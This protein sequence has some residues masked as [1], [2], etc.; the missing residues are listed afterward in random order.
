MSQVRNGRPPWRVLSIALAAFV[1]LGLIDGALGV[2]WPSMR[3]FF[4][5]GVAEL[6]LLLT[7]GSLGYMIAS[8][9]YGRLHERWGTG[10]LLGTGCTLLFLGA[11][12]YALSPLW[13]LVALSAWLLGLGGGL[14]DTG[15]NAHAALA[16]DVGSV[17]LLH[18]GY[19]VGA[20]MGP[21]V[22]TASLV[23]SS[24]WRWG[25][26]AIA[27]CQ[28][29]TTLAVWSQRSRWAAPDHSGHD[30]GSSPI[31][32]RASFLLAV[33]MFFLYTGMEVG[34]G[35][36]AFTLLAEGRG[37]STAAAGTW[38]A[39]YWGG[40]T[41]GRLVFGI[42][43]P[44][45]RPRAILGGSVT[46]VL[47][48][49][50]WLWLD[51]AGLGVIGLPIAGLG[52]AAVFPTLVSLTPE[53]LGRDMSTR[54]MG[55]QLAGANLG[56]AAIPWLLGLVAQTRGVATLAAGLF[57][58]GSVFAMVLLWSERMAVPRAGLNT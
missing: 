41:V 33:S 57:V 39:I 51:P 24:G 8:T 29:A 45:M 1:M 27:F 43:G 56:G 40:L 18:A 11:C 26:A 47:V 3:Q 35:Q 28:L 42:V 9:G 19:G 21:I 50:G 16:F 6:G 12:G 38:V 31:D 15:M 22:V 5:R 10:A 58:T 30:L 13:A 55:Y 34:T 25:Y 53:R 36:W 7:F 37:M 52:C 54:A 48:G 23:A 2:A 17:N 49:L 14:V 20:T 46:V 4:E 44:R 32:V